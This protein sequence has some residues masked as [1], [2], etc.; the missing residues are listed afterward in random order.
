MNGPGKNRAQN[1]GSSEPLTS[2]NCHAMAYQKAS[3]GVSTIRVHT[4]IPVFRNEI[5]DSVVD[6]Y[7]HYRGTGSSGR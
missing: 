7:P 2:S 5:L 1:L 3:T 6:L 4:E